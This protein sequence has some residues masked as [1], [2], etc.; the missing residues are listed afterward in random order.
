MNVFCRGQNGVGTPIDQ[1]IAPHQ[2]RNRL[3]HGLRCPLQIG[4]RPFLAVS[5][6]GQFLRFCTELFDDSILKRLGGS[7]RATDGRGVDFGGVFQFRW[8]STSLSGSARP[9][10]PV[11]GDHIGTAPGINPE[12]L[13]RFWPARRG[14]LPWI[15]SNIAR[16]SPMLV[17]QANPLSRRSGQRSGPGDLR[18]DWA[19][20]SRRRRLA[21][22]P[23]WSPR[24]RP[25]SAPVRF[26]DTGP[27]S[28]GRPCETGRRSPAAGCL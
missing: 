3:A 27:Q 5:D 1:H 11:P 24:S 10:R 23:T 14:T 15:A 4:S 26:Q 19:S 2:T 28:H 20:R 18:G 12:G 8:F 25:S 6:W 13:A 7:F 16:C 22:R 21:C 9:P 17:L